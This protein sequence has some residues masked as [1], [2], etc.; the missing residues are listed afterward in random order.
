MFIDLMITVSIEMYKHTISEELH[1]KYIHTY[2]SAAGGKINQAIFYVRTCLI[3]Y[4]TS[5]YVQQ[6]H[7]LIRTYMLTFFIILALQV[8]VPN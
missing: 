5:T 6:E 2:V 8:Y 7:V 3:F 1:T 4:S